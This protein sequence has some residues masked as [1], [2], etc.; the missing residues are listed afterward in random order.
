MLG[1]H[2]GHS[3]HPLPT[4]QEVTLH[5]HHHMAIKSAILQLTTEVND[6]LRNKR[7]EN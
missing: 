7:N 1:E 2:T 5:G 4:S 3:K 6:T